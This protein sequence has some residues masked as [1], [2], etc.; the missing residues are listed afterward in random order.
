MFHKKHINLN[1]QVYNYV[2]VMIIPRATILETNLVWS[3]KLTIVC[4]YT[5]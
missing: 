3:E 2:N 1:S 5:S 4:I